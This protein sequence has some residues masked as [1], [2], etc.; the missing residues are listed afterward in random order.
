VN[1]R[2]PVRGFTLVELIVVL[3]IVGILVT[4]AVPKMIGI[5]D[6]TQEASCRYLRENVKSACQTYYGST[7]ADRNPHYPA[8]WRTLYNPDDIPVC[9]AGGTWTYDPSKGKVVCDLHP[10]E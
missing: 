10:D 1:T 8:D 2:T 4:I 9:P 6:D 3:V 5:A 7:A